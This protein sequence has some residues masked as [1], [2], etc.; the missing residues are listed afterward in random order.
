MEGIVK[1]LNEEKKTAIVTAEDEK[2]Y[3]INNDGNLVVGDV[4]S[5]EKKDDCVDCST[6]KKEGHIDLDDIGSESGKHDCASCGK[7]CGF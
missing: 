1:E 7:C 5:F 4:I 6:I 3:E 2:D